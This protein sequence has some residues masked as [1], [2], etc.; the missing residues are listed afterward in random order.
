[1]IE[2]YGDRI[3]SERRRLKMTQTAFSKAVAISQ[4]TQVG[5]ESGAHLPN[6]Q[7]L[8]R[9]ASL[10]VDIIFVILG[11]PARRAAIDWIDWETYVQIVTA[12]DQWLEENL[13][14]VDTD[15]KLR[16]AKVLLHMYGSAEE[17]RQEEIGEHLKLVA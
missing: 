16:L 7:Y 15:K 2:N 6:I 12:I 11:K 9:S 14:A 13:A 1:V 4:A 10:G 3:R 17:I 5:Y 8:S